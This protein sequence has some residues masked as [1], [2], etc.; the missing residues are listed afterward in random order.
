VTPTPRAGA[1]KREASE[2]RALRETAA[3]GVD[4]VTPMIWPVRGR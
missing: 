4:F 1:I 3:W 2:I